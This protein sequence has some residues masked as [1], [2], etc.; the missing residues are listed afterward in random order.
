MDSTNEKYTLDYL[1]ELLS[2]YQYYSKEQIYYVYHHLNGRED[3]A[4]YFLNQSIE[5]NK[6]IN[7][8]YDKIINQ[9]EEKRKKIRDNEE[10]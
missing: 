10:K 1:I 3:E 4:A 2:G 5:Q 9:E 6:P 8:A 7:N